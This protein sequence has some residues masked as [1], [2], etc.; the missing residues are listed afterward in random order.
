[1]TMCS[2]GATTLQSESKLLIHHFCHRIFIGSNLTCVLLSRWWPEIP[3]VLAL[4]YA[5]A[6]MVDVIYAVR[7]QEKATSRYTGGS[8][9]MSKAGVHQAT[10]FVGAFYMTWVPYLILQVRYL[11]DLCYLSVSTLLTS[12]LLAKV[13]AIIGERLQQIWTGPCGKHNVCSTG[14]LELYC[15]RSPAKLFDRKESVKDGVWR[16]CLIQELYKKNVYW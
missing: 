4:F 2:F 12:C 15:L 10:L 11:L 14:L 1:M 8:S 13:H 9:K 6:I 16:E 5:T 3:I 7:Q